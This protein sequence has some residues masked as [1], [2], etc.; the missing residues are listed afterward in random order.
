MTVSDGVSRR[1]RPWFIALIVSVL[2]LIAASVW[3]TVVLLDGTGESV[4]AGRAGDVG[5][6]VG[7][8]LVAV[9][10]LVVS[11][12]QLRQ[13][14]KAAPAEGSGPRVPAGARIRQD[15]TASVP[16]AIAQGVIG[17]DIHNRF[18]SPGSDTRADPAEDG[19]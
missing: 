19:S 2:L 7:G 4:G 12:L 6:G 15:V 11:I 13:A 1:R 18:E 10:S 9:A 3:L 16:G 5:L 8:F 17:G 14:H